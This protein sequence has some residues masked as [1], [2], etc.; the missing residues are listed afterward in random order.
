[1][2]PDA[3]LCVLA[4]AGSGKTTVLARRVARR[5]LDGS[6]RAE[7]TLVVTFTR[8]ASRELRDRLDGSVSPAR[9]RPGRS[10]PWPSPNCAATGRTAT[11]GLPW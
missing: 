4:A 9:S 8:K 5:V 3:P 7:H 10:T 6:A 2:S 11:C 1:M